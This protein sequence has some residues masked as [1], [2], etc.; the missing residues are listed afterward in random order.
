MCIRDRSSGPGPPVLRDAQ[1]LYGYPKSEAKWRNLQHPHFERIREDNL[2]AERTAEAC[3]IMDGHKRPYAAEQPEPWGGAVCMFEF[4]S[5]K[6]LKTKGAKTVAFDQCRYG[7]P[8]KKPTVIIYNYGDFD[9]LECRCDHPAALQQ[10]KDGSTYWAP[11]PS[12]VGRKDESGKY[13]TNAL[14]AYPKRLNKKLAYILS[15]AVGNQHS[16]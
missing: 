1:H 9:E 2:L 3:D 7:A 8:C 12:Y 6:N 15:T 11:H 13:A 14:S 16:S 4:D 5:F 10:D